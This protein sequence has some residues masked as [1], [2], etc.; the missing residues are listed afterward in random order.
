MSERAQKLRQHILRFLPGTTSTPTGLL[1]VNNNTTIATTTNNTISTTNPAIGDVNVPPSKN[2]ETN[3][4]AQQTPK[5]TT[6]PSNLALPHVGYLDMPCGDGDDLFISG[7]RHVLAREGTFLAIVPSFFHSIST[8]KQITLDIMGNDLANTSKIT[9][10]VPHKQGNNNNNNMDKKM[11][12]I[13]KQIKLEHEQH[14]QQQQGNNNNNNN[15]DSSIDYQ[16]FFNS[17]QLEL[18]LYTPFSYQIPHPS[19]IQMLFNSYQPP[20]T[21][22]LSQNLSLFKLVQ[23]SKQVSISRYNCLDSIDRTGRAICYLYPQYLEF[24]STYLFNLTTFIPNI[25]TKLPMFNF[26]K[27]I[28]TQNNN[29]NDLGKINYQNNHIQEKINSIDAIP[30]IIQFTQ[31]IRE[32]LI[33]HSLGIDF[34]P[35]LSMPEITIAT[36]THNDDNNDNNNNNNNNNSHTPPHKPFK[37]LLHSLPSYINTITFDQ[38]VQICQ[39]FTRMVTS[40][41]MLWVPTW[42]RYKNG[43]NKLDYIINPLHYHN[44]ITMV[45]DSIN[46]NTNININEKHIGT[47][48][49]LPNQPGQPKSFIF[50][51]SHQSTTHR[52]MEE[53]PCYHIYNEKD[54]NIPQKPHFSTPHQN[55]NILAVF[56]SDNYH[57]ILQNLPKFTSLF[58]HITLT[59]TFL[60]KKQQYQIS[61]SPKQLHQL[62]IHPQHQRL[63]YSIKRVCEIYPNILNSYLNITPPILTT[64]FPMTLEYSANPPLPLIY[65]NNNGT[66][67]SN[68]DFVPKNLLNNLNIISNLDLI[69]PL[70]SILSSP[71]T[72]IP[73]LISICSQIIRMNELFQHL[74]RRYI[75]N[76]SAPRLLESLS[77]YFTNYRPSRGLLPL[78][79]YM[80]KPLPI[81]PTEDGN[82]SS[83]PT[84]YGLFHIYENITANNVEASHTVQSPNPNKYTRDH[85]PYTRMTPLLSVLG[86]IMTVFIGLSFLLFIPLIVTIP[87]LRHH[88]PLSP[89]FDH[90]D[91]DDDVNANHNEQEL[92]PL[93]APTDFVKNN[94]FDNLYSPIGFNFEPNEHIPLPIL[95]QLNNVIYKNPFDYVHNWVFTRFLSPGADTPLA[96]QECLI[97]NIEQSLEKQRVDLQHGLNIANQ[98]DKYNQI[99]L[100]RTVPISALTNDNNKDNNVDERIKGLYLKQD[101][102]STG[103]RLLFSLKQHQFFAQIDF[104]NLSLLSETVMYRDC[105]VALIMG[106]DMVKDYINKTKQVG[107]HGENKNIKFAPHISP[108]LYKTLPSQ[109]YIF[110]LLSFSSMGLFTLIIV[111]FIFLTLGLHF[112]FFFRIRSL[113]R[114]QRHWYTPPLAFSQQLHQSPSANRPPPPPPPPMS[115]PGAPKQPIGPQKPF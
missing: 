67:V 7:L 35:Q 87:D 95:T 54:G 56:Y 39:Q 12:K 27:L 34:H 4:T 71:I 75:D 30:Y 97:N 18:T 112:C 22:T 43:L 52:F 89:R 25:L 74:E 57:S 81:I 113:L 29:I 50:S 61:K 51:T 9:Y 98:I 64:T 108:K 38:N 107:N 88:T 23:I 48:W 84:R 36:N 109:F 65:M 85:N 10:F 73:L 5:S 62:S 17:N 77:I 16:E 105:N 72:I 26:E 102:L 59:E 111:P 92:L 63:A 6:G 79:G 90:H 1:T 101:H 11:A 47:N 19:Y 20:L 55:S 44:G 53:Y 100:I 2:T 104:P 110:D 115:A 13:M 76:M 45:N 46:T 69:S 37:Y 60:L 42:S 66:I 33:L 99:S 14:Q 78:T 91:D 80:V 32:F 86:A 94:Y 83:Q 68:D 24:I 40:T 15:N 96:I 28:Q 70:I 114:I 82:Q 106:N 49:L 3:S 103:K 8:Q 58:D 31:Y 21:S 93:T 41:W